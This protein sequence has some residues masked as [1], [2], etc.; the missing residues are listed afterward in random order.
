MYALKPYIRII[1][2]R[3]CINACMNDIT[4]LVPHTLPGASN[5]QSTSEPAL[6]GGDGIGLDDVV[7]VINP[8]QHIPFVSHLYRA[9]TGD[10]LSMG[11]QMIGGGVF[12]GVIG[13][14]SSFVT[15]VVEEA[16]GEPLL[17]T[18]LNALTPDAPQKTSA[19]YGAL[20]GDT[21][22]PDQGEAFVAMVQAGAFQPEA[23][24]EATT[25]AAPTP[26]TPNLALRS[27]RDE[28]LGLT[29]TDKQRQLAADMQQELA[30]LV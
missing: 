24:P 27:Y 25:Q 26:P 10:T 13:A 3:Y 18:A 14:A 22:V 4:T 29:N 2:H 8:L 28:A 15:A 1:W 30:R 7:D 11:A 17:D 21:L 16:T 9:A 6:F 12:G 5:Q 20:P 23:T 19:L